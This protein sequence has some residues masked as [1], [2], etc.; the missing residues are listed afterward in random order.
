ME[1]K[2]IVSEDEVTG[3]NMVVL[4]IELVVAEV[5]EGRVSEV[6]VGS[7]KD[8][9]EVKPV[10]VLRYRVHIFVNCSILLTHC[11]Y[12]DKL[13]DN[14][15]SYFQKKNILTKFTRGSRIPFFLN[16]IDVIPTDL[17][18]LLFFESVLKYL[19]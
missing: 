16:Y 17:L 6:L 9:G 2:V 12:N 19:R 5:V 13:L 3:K 15:Y 10:K 11:F 14:F 18:L 4:T 8:E 1:P 7:S